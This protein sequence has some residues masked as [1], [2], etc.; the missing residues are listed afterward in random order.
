MV[1]RNGKTYCRFC[2]HTFT[3]TGVSST[4]I[5]NEPSVWKNEPSI[6]WSKILP[7]LFVVIILGTVALALLAPNTLSGIFFKNC[8]SDIRSFQCAQIKPQYCDNGK[9]VDR[10][11][12]CGCPYWLREYNNSCIRIDNCTDGTLAPDCSQNKPYQ[13]L[14]GTLIENTGL[15]GCPEDYAINNETCIEIERCSDGTIYG[16][17]SS[18]KPLF[19]LNGTLIEKATQ[20]G[21]QDD[22]RLNG[23]AC[24][25]IP[26]C[27][28]GTMDGQCSETKPKLCSGTTLIDKA[29]TCGCPF[30]LDVQQVGDRCVDKRVEQ[31][32]ARVHTLINN[33]RAVA[34]LTPLLLDSVLSDIARKH[35][36]DMALGGYFDHVNREGLDPSGRATKEGYS[37]TKSYGS[38]Y[39]YGVAENINQVPYGNVVGCG[40]VSS[41]ED[42]ASC[43]VDGW[44][45]SAGHRQ[46]ILTSTYDRE[47][48]G[49]SIAGNKVYITEDFC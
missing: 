46:N 49:V 12:L 14:N 5:F 33:E 3:P 23:E 2:Y 9:L 10:A 21:C 13:C 25:E 40:Y 4:P 34:G 27:S 7:F 48:I 43:A 30:G 26:K 39:T 18:N 1:V 38:Y 45:T 28:D 29:S 37:C 47:G 17:C 8:A 36:A 15:C 22:Y 11:D 41:S 44:M 32:E 24:D 35:S 16:N 19:C 42:V 31:I 6:W 20:C